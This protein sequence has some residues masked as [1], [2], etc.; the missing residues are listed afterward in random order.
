MPLAGHGALLGWDRPCCTPGDAW[1]DPCWGFGPQLFFGIFSF[2]AMSGIVCEESG[3]GGDGV[4]FS[5]ALGH[6]KQLLGLSTGAVT[7]ARRVC[8]TMPGVPVEMGS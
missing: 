8:G 5:P 2:T 4:G 7:W 3:W 6:V 1:G